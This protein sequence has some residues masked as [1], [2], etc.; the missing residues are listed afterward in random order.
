MLHRVL[1]LLWSVAKL[2]YLQM[3]IPQLFNVISLWTAII[4]R[5]N[6]DLTDRMTID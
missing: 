3:N 4:R 1:A 5:V 6:V 2:R